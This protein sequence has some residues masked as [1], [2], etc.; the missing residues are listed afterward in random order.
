MVRARIVIPPS[1]PNTRSSVNSRSTFT[2]PTHQ[3]HT[4]TLHSLSFSF[5]LSCDL[6]GRSG[7]GKGREVGVLSG[8]DEGDGW[9]RRRRREE[10]VDE[11][12]EPEAELL[13]VLLQERLVELDAAVDDLEEESL[14]VCDLFLAGCLGVK[15][16]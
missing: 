16:A 10:V 2:N 3:L 13:L 9:E 7:G 4:N 5:F 6:A 15:F 1:S 8:G 14:V 11:V 12:G